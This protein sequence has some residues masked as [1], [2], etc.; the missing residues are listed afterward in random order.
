MRNI[1][2]YTVMFV[3]A[4]V[5]MHLVV[6]DSMQVSVL[7]SPLAY[8]AFVVLLP[9]NTRPVAVLLLGFV[10]GMFVDFFEG[11]VGLHTAATLAT[12]YARRGVMLLTLG[13]DV[14]QQEVAMPSVRSLGRARF[15]RYAV[16][17]VLLHCL[18]LFSLEALT[19]HNY[20]LVL[21]K[22]AVSALFTLLAVWAVSLLFTVKTPAKV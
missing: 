14:V 17:M 4:V 7:F 21:L 8:I 6:L 16:A 12:A 15:L 11:S 22:T 5:L 1:L 18:I 19:W 10:T 2:I 13:G 9:V 3:V 20:P